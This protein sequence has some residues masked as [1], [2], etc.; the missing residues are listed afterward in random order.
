MV[1]AGAG[2]VIASPLWLVISLVIVVESGFPVFY[3]REVAGWRGK[4]FRVLKFRTMR[5]GNTL[6]A[7]FD[8]KRDPRVT[9]VGRLLRPTALDELPSLL[10]ILRGE[11]SF[12]GPR[13]LLQRVEDPA[14]PD[15]GRESRALPRGEFRLLVRPGLTGLAQ[16]Y[17]PKNL[18]YRQKFRYDALYIRKMSLGLDIKLML[19]SFLRTFA[20]RWEQVQTRRAHQ[21]AAR[22]PE[23]GLS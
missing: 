12:V 3:S 5:K 23:G 4:P 16:L 21:A 18:P 20:R 15:H 7:D 2:L 19:M 13:V 9:R 1:L 6:V 11:M 10:H 22:N 14:D 8:P 17:A